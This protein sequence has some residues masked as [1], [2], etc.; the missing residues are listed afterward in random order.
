MVNR[1]ALY[2]TRIHHYRRHPLSHG[3]SYRGYWWLVDIDRPD[4]LPRAARLLWRL[5]PQDYCGDPE[6]SIADNVRTFLKDNG[7][8]T[9]DLRISMLSTPRQFGY[10]FNPITLYYCHRPDGTLA[11][12]IAEVHNTYGGRHR[13]LLLPDADYTSDAEK[14]LYVSPFF[15]ESGRYRIHAPIPETRLS[16]AVRLDRDGEP[17]FIASVVG[18]RV[19]FTTATVAASLIIGSPLLTSARIRYQGIRLWLKGLK[20]HPRNHPMEVCHG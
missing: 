19:P 1:T 3:F 4:A 15:D 17:P 9:T 13:Y 18:E 2:R 8:D 6:L 16:L 20:V 5:R 7:C 12:Q 14:R 11:A 10:G